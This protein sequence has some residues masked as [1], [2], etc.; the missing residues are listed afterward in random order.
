MGHGMGHR[1]RR[2]P[3]VSL[4]MGRQSGVQELRTGGAFERKCA[5]RLHEWRCRDEGVRPY[6]DPCH[7]PRPPGP[8]LV[9]TQTKQAEASACSVEF[10]SPEAVLMAGDIDPF[11]DE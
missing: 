5:V 8:I 7:R 3:H 11:P 1:A 10:P 2:G 4:A 6:P 9:V